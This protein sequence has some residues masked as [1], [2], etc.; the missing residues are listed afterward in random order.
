MEQVDWAAADHQKAAPQQTSDRESQE[1]ELSRACNQIE[2]S[3]QMGAQAVD[4]R[5]VAEDG[6]AAI[7]ARY[8][9]A[10]RA[11][12]FFAAEAELK[13]ML[14]LTDEKVNRQKEYMGKDW[15]DFHREATHWRMLSREEQEKKLHS[16]VV[17]GK[18]ANVETVT[19]ICAA[20]VAPEEARMCLAAICAHIGKKADARK[21]LD[22]ATRINPL[23]ESTLLVSN[24]KKACAPAIEDQL[25]ART[26]DKASAGLPELTIEDRSPTV[27]NAKSLQSL[28]RKYF[29]RVDLNNDG[30]L[31]KAEI[32]KALQNKAHHQG[33]A[34]FIAAAKVLN[35][36]LSTQDHPSSS[37][38]SREDFGG[39]ANAYSRQPSLE[40]GIMAFTNVL[41]KFDKL[42]SSEARVSIATMNSTITKLK[43]QGNQDGTIDD[44]AGVIQQ[45]RQISPSVASYPNSAKFG[46]VELKRAL[47][48]LTTE[49]RNLLQNDARL[50]M[51]QTEHANRKSGLFA[52]GTKPLESIKPEAVQQGSTGD[53]YFLAA[54][55][56]MAAGRP[57]AL[58]RAV[59][60]NKDGTYTVTFPG[61]K[62][63]PIT[64]EE[65]T[66]AELLVYAAGNSYGKWVAVME[67]AY[68]AY[69]AK[70]FTRRHLSDFFGT[71]HPTDATDGGTLEAGMQMFSSKSETLRDQPESVLRQKLAEAKQIGGAVIVART[72]LCPRNAQWA[73]NNHAYAVTN[74]DAKTGNVTVRNPWGS[75]ARGSEG[76]VTKTMTITEFANEFNLFCFGR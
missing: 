26:P 17:P 15:E 69:C 53:C 22:E 35:Q 25:E 33:A 72:S 43:A 37:T 73:E 63:E 18:A 36:K 51:I 20:A 52:D 32:D 67:K 42:F 57:A 39:F 75:R 30:E 9:K 13:A 46:K 61:A 1:A 65:P 60:A 50:E 19:A 3:I 34:V 58:A 68:G 21:W 38:I 74:Y 29:N 24:T 5:P 2:G 11:G 48:S 44:L 23:V 71:N 59:V 31:S 76:T 4:A 55:A 41:E 10:I 27:L 45:A 47:D 66:E 12:L 54:M 8:D 7:Y 6:M 16:Y 40:H 56:A 14:P 49:H 28:S 70:S 62:G 64:V